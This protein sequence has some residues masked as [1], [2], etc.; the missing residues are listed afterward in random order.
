MSRVRAIGIMPAALFLLLSGCVTARLH[1]E[2]E[3]A[4]VGR[5]CG[6]ALGELF[7]DQS[8]KRLLF[9]FRI[10]PTA[11]QRS[12][13]VRWARKNKLKTVIVEAMNFPEES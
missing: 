4:D 5:D 13:V 8:E 10:E 1:S 12:C 2:A 9:M 3:L 7:Q 6:L 11:E